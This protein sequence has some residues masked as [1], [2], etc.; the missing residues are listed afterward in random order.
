MIAVLLDSSHGRYAYGPF[1][2]FEQLLAER[3]AAFLTAEVDP[4]QVVDASR[5]LALGLPFRSPL[6]ELLNWRD[7]VRTLAWPLVPVTPC[8]ACGQDMPADHH[9]PDKQQAAPATTETAHTT[10]ERNTQ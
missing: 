7:S 10:D 6:I 2:D 8:S 9:C 3:F 4:A 5:A 1:G